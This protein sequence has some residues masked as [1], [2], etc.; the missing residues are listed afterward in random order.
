[1]PR[2]DLGRMFLAVALV[3]SAAPAGA[4]SEKGPPLQPDGGG[5][6]VPLWTSG[7]PASPDRKLH[8]DSVPKFFKRGQ[9]LLSNGTA[10]VDA[11]DWRAVAMSKETGNGACTLTLVGPRV[12]LLAAHCVDAGLPPAAPGRSTIPVEAVFDKRVY[13]L[14]CEMSPKY[15]QS[16]VNPMGAPRASDD[17]ALCDVELKG[18]AAS[19]L[20]EVAPESLSTDISLSAGANIQMMG[21]GCTNLGISAD[22]RYTYDRANGTLNMGAEK[23]E[24]TSISIYPAMAGIYLRALSSDGG[25]VLCPGDSGGPV[26]TGAPAGPGRRVVAVNSALGATPEA[27]AA[28]PAFNSYFAPLGSADFRS[29]LRDWV[30]QLS[31]TDPAKRKDRRVCGFGITPGTGGCRP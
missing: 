27:T 3:T 23:V 14:A 25:P 28:K 5:L 12:A 10:V 18:S 29:F 15:R 30:G 8:F 7:K 17:F 11:K 2:N 24:A 21:Y 9:I 16:A 31:I 22:G 13:D 26:M 19:A 1:M 6:A 4:E 20:D